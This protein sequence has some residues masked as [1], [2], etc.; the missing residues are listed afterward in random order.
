M[1]TNNF[2]CTRKDLLHLESSVQLKQPSLGLM[3]D[4]FYVGVWHRTWEKGTSLPS[5]TKVIWF[6]THKFF[7]DI[8]IPATSREL[9]QSFA[10]HTTIEGNR[11]QWH[12]WCSL[13]SLLDDTASLEL[14]KDSCEIKEYCDD[15]GEEV[16]KKENKKIEKIMSLELIDTQSNDNIC[17]KYEET[18]TQ[19]GFLLV[20]EN[21]FI[22]VFSDKKEGTYESCY[23]NISKDGSFIVSDSTTASIEGEILHS[24]KE[25]HRFGDI[26]IEEIDDFNVR[27]WFV[28][29]MKGDLTISEGDKIVFQT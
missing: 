16:W 21:E 15:G 18:T 5:S 20:L 9:Q 13:S 14:S 10:G 12:Q 6:Q 11:C 17:A 26:I 2:A 25:M 1:S 7:A 8:R 23:G 19:K 29:E 3:L 22:R 4:D 27:R 24:N 28:H